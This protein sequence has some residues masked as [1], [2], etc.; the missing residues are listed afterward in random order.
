MSNLELI[1]ALKKASHQYPG[2]RNPISAKSKPFQSLKV[3]WTYDNDAMAAILLLGLTFAFMPNG[4][5][6]EVVKTRQVTCLFLELKPARTPTR[7]DE[8]V[9]GRFLRVHYVPMA[10]LTV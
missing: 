2:R 8:V 9:G 7:C 4:F 1:V 5:S 3:P 6:I 10:Y